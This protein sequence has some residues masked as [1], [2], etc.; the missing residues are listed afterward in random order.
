MEVGMYRMPKSKGP[1]KTGVSLVA[2]LPFA[3][4]VSFRL[5]MDPFGSVSF[6]TVIDRI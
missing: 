4:V 1:P 3:N 5:T 6:V 2:T